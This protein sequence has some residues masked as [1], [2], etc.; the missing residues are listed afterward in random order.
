MNKLSSIKL[1][2]DI[3][4]VGTEVY[5]IIMDKGLAQRNA[6]KDQKIKDLE[7]ELKELKKEV[8]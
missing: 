2:A 7:R 4:K 8:K 6:D 3:A 1:I 5:G